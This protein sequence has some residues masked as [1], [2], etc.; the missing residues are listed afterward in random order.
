MT[1][2]GCSSVEGVPVA[3][4]LPDGE[5]V[6]DGAGEPI[7]TLTGADGT[8]S[9]PQVVAGP[10]EVAVDSP[11]GCVP[12]GTGSL[13]APVDEGAVEGLVLALVTAPVATT[14]PTTG[15]S[16]ADAALVPVFTG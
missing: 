9:F 6:L 13:P 1:T 12:E 4:T 15:A 7:T 14:D 2:D 10:F 5:P 8:W 3:L 11:P 16:D